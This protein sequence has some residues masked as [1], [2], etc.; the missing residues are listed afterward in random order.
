[1]KVKLRTK[2]F[3]LSFIITFA[4]FFTL[5]LSNKY[6]YYEY[7]KHEQVTLTNEEIKRFEQDVKD[8]KNTQIGDYLKH[9]NKNYQT[10]FSQAGLNLSNSISKVIKSGV[11]SF[12][13]S[14]DKMVN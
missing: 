5:F 14:I 6:G 9:T 11:E 12:F 10:K 2:V 7:K 1:M 4:I 8:G 3:R 13:A